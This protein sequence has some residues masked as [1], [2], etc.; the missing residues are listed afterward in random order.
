MK[1]SNGEYSR[2]IPPPPKI[3]GLKFLGWGIKKH[4]WPEYSPLENIFTIYQVTL[5]NHTGLGFRTILL[6]DEFYLCLLFHA[7]KMLPISNLNYFV[8]VIA[9]YRA[10]TACRWTW[11]HWANEIQKILTA[12]DKDIEKNNRTLLQ[13]QCDKVSK[14]QSNSR[15]EAINSESN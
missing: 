4:F 14:R 2:S 1:I 3:F 13:Y 9:V 8:S 10:A 7:R 6:K 15:D 12:K 11:L 5:L